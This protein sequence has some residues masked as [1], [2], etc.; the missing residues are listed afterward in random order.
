MS[1]S[2]ISLFIILLIVLL[3]QDYSFAQCPMCRMTAESNMQHGGTAGAGLNVGILYMLSLPYLLVG[4]IGY[5][6]Y[7]NRRREGEDEK[8]IWN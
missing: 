4:M 5:L 6:W 7:K 2:V 3:V 8:H 1:K